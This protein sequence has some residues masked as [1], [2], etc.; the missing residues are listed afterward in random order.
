M[1]LLPSLGSRGDISMKKL[2]FVSPVILNLGPAEEVINFAFRG[3]CPVDPL[4]YL[5]QSS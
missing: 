3:G 1:L 2:L 5:M 4:P